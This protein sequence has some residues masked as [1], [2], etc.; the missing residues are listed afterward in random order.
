L[1][2]TTVDHMEFCWV[3]SG[4]FWMGHLEEYDAQPH[5]NKLLPYDYWISRFPIT[6]AQYQVFVTA[7]NHQPDD[8]KCLKDSA[9]R[10]VRYVTWHE[11]VKF[12]DWLTRYWHERGVLTKERRVQLP[13]EAE[14]EK[15]A[16][17]GIKVPVQSSVRPVG[18]LAEASQRAFED[19]ENPE[20]RFPWGD[21]EDANRANYV[22]TKIGDTSAVG[23]FQDGQSPYGCEEMSG[24]VWEW[25]RSLYRPYPYVPS[26][27]RENQDAPDSE[28]RVVRGGAFDPVSLNIRCSSR[29]R[30]DFDDWYNFIGFRVVLSL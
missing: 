4:E 9:N 14:W 16:R 30:H 10:P 3:P 27:G 2:V 28:G 22:H 21:E 1:E 19:N 29:F 24:N 8:P 11:A 5:L 13:S 15:A 7:T 20:R 23:C 6:V 25:T 18:E 12:C 26:D 17:G